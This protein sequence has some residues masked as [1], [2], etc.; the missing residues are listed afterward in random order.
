MTV[1]S[2]TGEDVSIDGKPAFKMDTGFSMLALLGNAVNPIY[3]GCNYAGDYYVHAADG[4]VICRWFIERYG[5]KAFWP[6][7]ATLPRVERVM[8]V[9]R[10]R[11]MRRSMLERAVA[12]EILSDE[13]LPR[14]HFLYNGEDRQEIV[15]VGLN[16]Y[17]NEQQYGILDVNEIGVEWFCG[18]V[19]KDSRRTPVGDRFVL[20]ADHTQQAWRQYG[21]FTHILSDLVVVKL[22]TDKRSTG[23]H[24][25][26]INGRPYVFRFYRSRAKYDQSVKVETLDDFGEGAMK[27]TVIE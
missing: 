6:P 8:R 27:E 13:T 22:L 24:R 7:S 3:E 1:I 23:I 11:A 12:L 25:F 16:R 21:R 5:W 19:D 2:R 14:R 10:A 9:L 18:S 4:S 26:V 17:G 20:A 15:V